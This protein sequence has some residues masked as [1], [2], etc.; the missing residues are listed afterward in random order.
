MHMVARPSWLSFHSITL[1]RVPL[2]VV[3]AGTGAAQEVTQGEGFVE[4]DVVDGQ[5]GAGLTAREA[6]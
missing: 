1:N 2:L 5:A 3:G 6:D 4:F